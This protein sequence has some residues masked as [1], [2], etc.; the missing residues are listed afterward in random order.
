MKREEN[1]LLHISDGRRILNK[2]KQANDPACIS[3]LK[4][5][6]I[7]CFQVRFFTSFFLKNNIDL[8]YQFKKGLGVTHAMEK[9]CI[10]ALRKLKVE[11][12]VAPYEADPQLAYLCHI[13]YCKGVLS[14]DSDILMYSAACGTS[15][16]ILYKYDPNIGSV[17]VTDIAKLGILPGQ[18]PAT[19]I[20]R[21]SSA[22]STAK[23]SKLSQ[24]A[25]NFSNANGTRM[26]V[27]MCL[28]AGCDYCESIHGVGI[29]TALQV[30]THTHPCSETLLNRS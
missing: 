13:G 30:L 5:E 29:I 11:V 19:K 20:T 26:F 1:R 22:D 6:C 14:E 15:F 10:A 23:P 2:L 28:L 7:S 18:S 8:T 3:K 12:I 9:S 25:S 24:V 16:P 27:Q 4:N 17:Q 21:Q